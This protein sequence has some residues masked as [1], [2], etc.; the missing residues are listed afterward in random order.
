MISTWVQTRWFQVKPITLTKFSINLKD[1]HFCLFHKPEL[2]T[3]PGYFLLWLGHVNWSTKLGKDLSQRKLTK[4]LETFFF[5]FLQH[6]NQTHTGMNSHKL[7]A[8]VVFRTQCSQRDTIQNSW[9]KTRL[10]IQIVSTCHKE[11]LF[12]RDF[13]FQRKLKTCRLSSSMKIFTWSLAQE[14]GLVNLI[15]FPASIKLQALTSTL[16]I[17]GRAIKIKQCPLRWNVKKFRMYTLQANILWTIRTY[18]TLFSV[19]NPDFGILRPLAW[20]LFKT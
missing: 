2:C 4:V 11:L 12:Q 15:K 16:V 10:I 17:S 18:I 7:T 19:H 13:P 8:L 5:F 3:L 6:K 20:S 14:E 9:A 1:A